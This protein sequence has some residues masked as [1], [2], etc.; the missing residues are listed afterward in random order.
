MRRAR[1]V[2]PTHL[3]DFT[4]RTSIPENRSPIGQRARLPAVVS[5]FRRAGCHA[6]G[7]SS[8][9][10]ASGSNPLVTD[11]RRISRFY[12]MVCNERSQ[13]ERDTLSG[14]NPGSRQAQSRCEEVLQILPVGERTKALRGRSG[15]RPVRF[16]QRRWR[17]ESSR[18]DTEKPEGICLRGSAER[19]RTAKSSTMRGASSPCQ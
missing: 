14:A 2:M 12:L 1:Q 16:A 19:R 5:G 15:A 4:R 10:G 9:R 17:R 8:S 11:Q 13:G 7:P 3:F 18:G 6:S